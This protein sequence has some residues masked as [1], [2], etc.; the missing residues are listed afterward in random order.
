[1]IG[2]RT[3]RWRDI[4]LF[5]IN[6]FLIS[7]LFTITLS[8]FLG[9]S[10]TE[11]FVSETKN[12]VVLTEPGWEP[13]FSTIPTY[14]VEDLLQLEG[15]IAVSPETVDLCYQADANR[16]VFI[17]GVTDEFLKVLDTYWIRAGRWLNFTSGIMEAVAGKRYADQA[18]L[19]PGKSILLVSRRTDLIISVTIVGIIETDTNADDSI[20]LPLWIGQLLSDYATTDVKLMR[21]RFDPSV[22]SSKTI[23]ETVNSEFRI[24]IELLPFNSTNFNPIGTNVSVYDRNQ[25]QIESMAYSAN[26][27]SI[28]FLLPFGTYSFVARPPD[29]REGRPISAFIDRDGLLELP[30]GIPNFNL[31]VQVSCNDRAAIA[32]IVTAF[33]NETHYS[34]TKKTSTE[35]S[36]SFVLPE[37]IYSLHTNYRGAQNQTSFSL[38]KSSAIQINLTTAI[39]VTT[40]NATTMKAL[41]GVNLALFDE[42]DTLQ[43]STITDENG[44]AYIE[45]QPGPAILNTSLA[46]FER[47]ELLTLRGYTELNLTLGYA[48]AIVNVFEREQGPV[49]N[50]TVEVKETGI[51]I[52]NDT[53]NSSGIAQFELVVGKKYEFYAR[54]EEFDEENSVFIRFNQTTEISLLLGS[55]DLF[56]HV[57]NAKTQNPVGGAELTITNINNTQERLTTVTNATGYG[58]V[59]TDY[60]SYQI[61]ANYAG[62]TAIGGVLFSAENA[63][64]VTI[65][66]LGNVS[67]NLTIMGANNESINARVIFYLEPAFL[68]L[69]LIQEIRHV[70]TIWTY[71]GRYKVE[72]K[73]FALGYTFAGELSLFG[74]K[75][76][77]LILHRE[78]LNFTLIF[79]ANG[80]ITNPKTIIKFT[81]SGSNDAAQYRWDGGLDQTTPLHQLFGQTNFYLETPGPSGPHLLEVV[82][83]GTNGSHLK[84]QFIFIVVNHLPKV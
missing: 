6:I 24:F 65:L 13:M 56:I 37:G 22:S 38:Y 21:I 14:L 48:T 45:S 7:F 8:I 76:Q 11:P 59:A 23:R 61:T 9:I 75:E 20:L 39:Q 84:A 83:F 30:V 4:R 29:I 3:I 77:T 10:R 57:L 26:E 74:D 18:G 82:L 40:F 42:N 5:L 31:T 64:D 68:N 53:T 70:S 43:G 62:A 80:S 49:G 44:R 72:A 51:V 12:T 33:S 69:T 19:H 17:R 52:E 73:N 66:R 58:W 67:V 34:D 78:P 28:T 25:I 35:G 60:G 50:T 81:C 46:P 15:T 1:M 41:P 55:Q 27:Q 79:P 2:L 71:S 36:T 63:R 16:P 32:A 54:A 47:T